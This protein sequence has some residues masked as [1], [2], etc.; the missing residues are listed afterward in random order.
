VVL[1]NL[2]NKQQLGIGQE[3]DPMTTTVSTTD[4]STSGSSQRQALFHTGEKPSFNMGVQAAL[5]AAGYQVVDQGC[6]G[7]MPS[8]TV[9]NTIYNGVP[10]IQKFLGSRI[11]P[12]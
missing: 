11:R 10:K 7:S 8:L 3:G 2:G 4:E 6:G 5:L 1:F 12:G 9:G